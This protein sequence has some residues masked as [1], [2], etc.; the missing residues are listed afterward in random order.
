MNDKGE[1]KLTALQAH[2]L[3]DL[4]QAVNDMG[5]QKEDIVKILDKDEGYFLLYYK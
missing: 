3:R 1:K 2:S 5:I 4:V